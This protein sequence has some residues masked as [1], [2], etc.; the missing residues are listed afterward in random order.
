M[1]D[2][3]DL[4]SQESLLINAQLLFDCAQVFEKFRISWNLFDHIKQGNVHL[5]LPQHLQD[6]ILLRSLLF[7]S[8]CLGKW[9]GGGGGGGGHA[10]FH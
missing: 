9:G 2:R 6:A 1:D 5:D 8:Q 4:L 10:S 3:A 7:S